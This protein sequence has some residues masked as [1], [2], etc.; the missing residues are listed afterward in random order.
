MENK[1]GNGEKYLVEE[2][3]AKFRK[4]EFTYIHTCIVDSNGDEWTTTALDE[5]NI[6]QIYNQYRLRHGIPFPDEISAIR[7]HYGLSA[8]KMSQILGFGTNQY[9][10]YEDGEIP[11]LSNART[12]IAAKDRN[13]FLSF[14]EASKKE[15]TSAEYKRIIGKV[16]GLENEMLTFEKPSAY[17][18]YISLNIDKITAVVQTIIH[19]VGPTFITKLNKLLYYI[20]FTHYRD[21][22]F[23]I[24][25][26]SYNALPY[27]PVPD[28]WGSIY[29][30]LDGVSMEEYVYSGGLSGIRLELTEEFCGSMLSEKELGTIDTIC[31]SYGNMSAGEISRLSH[32]EK[33]WIDNHSSRSP[34]SYDTA[35][36]ISR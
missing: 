18:G 13:I 33:G 3:K 26:L 29:S 35:F 10:L 19:K 16:K 23:G 6:F 17:T 9:R 27:G 4:E 32:Q 22:G 34:I 11:S 1:L 5:A 36:Y 24:T 12:I 31:K 7:K 20:D 8:A 15:Y 28:S 30:S 2:R 25:G 21:S 14:I